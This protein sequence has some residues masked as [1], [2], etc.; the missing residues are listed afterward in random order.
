MHT[1]LHLYYRIDLPLSW[2]RIL[3]ALGRVPLSAPVDP[4]RVSVSFLPRDGTS[5]LE[6]LVQGEPQ[7]VDEERAKTI[8]Q[9]ED[10]EISIEL[11]MGSEEARYWTCDFSH[12]SLPLTCSPIFKRYFGRNM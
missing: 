10:V 3:A 6:L 4:T 9:N 1:S 5:P 11:G 8:I 12:V 2:G 7:R